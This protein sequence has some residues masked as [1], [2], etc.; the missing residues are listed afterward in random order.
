MLNRRNWMKSLGVATAACALET[1]L[2]AALNCGP[3]TAPYGVQACVAGI[4]QEQLDSVQAFQE[5][6]QWCWAACIEMVFTFWGHP[7]DQQ[8]IVTQT[9]GRLVNMPAQPYQIIADLNR[10][11]KDSNGNTFRAQ[12]DVYSASGATAAQDLTNGMPLILGSMGHAMMLTAIAY[13]RAPNGQGQVTGA[14]VRDPWPGRGRRVL[15]AQEAAA[16]M[17]LAR[18]RVS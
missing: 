10:T 4:P 9:W 2:Q 13:N 3:Q 6:T 12:G 1:R 5:Q 16:T 17:L 7:I 15:S 14:I 18:I 8:D 11:W